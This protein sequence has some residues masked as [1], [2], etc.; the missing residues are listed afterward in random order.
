MALVISGCTRV[1]T[2]GP[3]GLG[4]HN[5]WTVPGVLRVGIIEDLDN[6]NP[7]L[8]L[9]SYVGDVEELV[10]SGLVQYDDH[11]RLIGD[12]ALQAPTLANGGISRDGLTITYHLRHNVA[13]SDGA[14]LTAAD[15]KFTWQQIMNPRNNLPNR[16][17]ADQVTSMDT[18]DPY[19]VV[20]H[21]RA[22][23]APFIGT[24]FQ[25]GS[26]PNGGIL[27]KHL[28]EHYRD[29]NQ[30][31]FNAH[32][33]GSGPFAVERWEPG[34]GL[35]L[36]A[37]PHYFR[38]VPGLQQIEI[39]II[40]SQNSL[41]TA[42]RSH[43]IDMY[44]DAAEIQYQTLQ[45]ISGYR[46]FAEPTFSLEHI[47]FNCA[48]PLLKDAQVRRAIAYAIDWHRLAS[49][50]YL[51]LGVPGMAD[52]RPDSWAYNP[53]ATQY[54]YDP[55]KARALL[56]AAGWKPGPDG[57]MQKAGVPLRLEMMTVVGISARLKAEEL[58]QQELKGVGIDI[59]I[60]NYPANLVFA[61]YANNGLL[62]RGRFDLA[63]VTMD[64]DPDPD[65]SIN[66]SPDQLPPQGQNRSFYVDPQLG[67]WEQAGRTNYD[68]AI[69]RKYYW[70]TQQR[71]HDAVP[72]HGI[73]WRPTINAVN[74]DLNNFKPGSSN[75]FWNAYAWSIK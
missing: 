59:D 39:R 23:Y 53:A 47:K 3:G 31:P 34:S 2:Q 27:P 57:I 25:N 65:N 4:Q 60:H 19:T 8:S 30:A 10:Y 75:D 67:A 18:P 29:L 48:R 5:A 13:F 33:V 28:L 42:L 61:T 7:L 66:F 26:T 9:Q 58:V 70:L 6:L 64:L 24:F 49:D 44:Y 69:R 71:I 20:V 54:P 56:A 74:A 11:Y 72:I 32:P 51:N 36:R 22:P 15:V 38:G 16:V 12:A 73:V 21:L 55:A 35:V 46:V 37:N 1:S 68:E 63:L 62:T 43:E 52:V 45:T 40:P 17:P 41:L 14:P 50:V